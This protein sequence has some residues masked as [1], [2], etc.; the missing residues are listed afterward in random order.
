MDPETIVGESVE[1]PASEENGNVPVDAPEVAPAPSP[2]PDAPVAAAE[3]QATPA[4]TPEPVLVELPDGRKVDA[5]TVAAEYKNLLSDYTKKSQELAQLK[6]PKPTEITKP[7]DPLQDPNYVPATYGEL[8]K[9]IA[10]NIAK[11]AKAK[12][13]AAN[14]ERLA[15]ETAV[16]EQLAEV[17]KID[18]TVNETALF[19]HAT[20]YGIRD[21]KQAY[22]NMQDM[23]KLAK[24]VKQTTAK[25]ILKRNDPVS[26]VPGTT[27]GQRPNPSNFQTARD[28]LRSI[29]G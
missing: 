10:D 29:T 18:K 5:V 19:Q 12:E 16:N 27:G 3:D 20:K 6:G 24:N 1:A 8:A 13:D 9:V 23:A 15:L 17:K 14:A 22:Q 7:A 2:A 11:E 28:Y 21:L 25:D 26:I 4:A